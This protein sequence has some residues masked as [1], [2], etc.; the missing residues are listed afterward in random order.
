MSTTEHFEQ[1]RQLSDIQSQIS[2]LT[3]RFSRGSGPSPCDVLV[4]SVMCK[5]LATLHKSTPI[6]VA[7]QLFPYQRDIAQAIRTPGSVLKAVAPAMTTVAGWASELV[8]PTVLGVLPIIAPRSAYSQLSQLPATIRADLAGHGSVKVPTRAPSPTLAPP[9]VGEGQPIPIRQAAVANTALTRRKAAVI[10][11][12][13]GEMLNRSAVDIE[14]LIRDVMAFDA[15]AAID[16]VLL[17]SSAATAIAPA[18]ILNGVTASAP[19]AGGSLA[20]LAGDVRILA[21]AIE[22]TGPLIAPTL[23]MSSTSALIVLLSLTGGIV[24]SVQDDGPQLAIV[25]APSV[26]SK[27]LIMIDAASFASGEG[28][29]PDFMTTTE[30]LLHEDTAPLPIGTPGGVPG[31]DPNIVAAPARSLFQT[32]AIAVRMLTDCGWTMTRAGRVAFIDSVTW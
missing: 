11:E 4:R 14:Q 20:A 27:R 3:A 18:G 9:F 30:A 23:I 17:G 10:S 32:N 22:A 12:F 2:K 15:S 1:R 16:G 8:T 29:A 28:D 7:E 25:A 19:T 26:P 5:V 6:A 24:L 21:A 31:T 13:T